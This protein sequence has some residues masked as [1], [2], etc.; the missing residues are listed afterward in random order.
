MRS[1]STV[2]NLTGV[3]ETTRGETEDGKQENTQPV[4]LTDQAIDSKEYIAKYLSFT[5]SDAI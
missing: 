4:N 3:R 1:F 2:R 5:K